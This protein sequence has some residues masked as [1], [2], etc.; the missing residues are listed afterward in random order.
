[1]NQKKRPQTAYKKIQYATFEQSLA[2]DSK[3]CPE[4]SLKY[5]WNNP[6]TFLFLFQMIS[7]TQLIPQ[8]WKNMV[9]Q[10]PFLDGASSRG[11][12]H[13]LQ[14]RQNRKLKLK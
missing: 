8:Q 7:F 12:S 5:S 1:M 10:F 2:R 14:G 3:G 6:Y 4:K 9:L 13:H 11:C